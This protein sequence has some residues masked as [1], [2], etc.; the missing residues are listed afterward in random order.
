M[1]L[2]RAIEGRLPYQVRRW[3]IRRRYTKRNLTVLEERQHP[4]GP[5]LVIES[6]WLCDG[7]DEGP[8]I[9]VRALGEE[10]WRIDL[11]RRRPHLHFN[12]IDNR[13]TRSTRPSNLLLSSDEIDPAMK[14]LRKNFAFPFASNRRRAL[15]SVVIDPAHYEPA[16]N[17]AQLHLE[18]LVNERMVHG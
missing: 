3:I 11:L 7:G 13:A 17:A 12:V 9:S 1:H 5:G 18:G 15:R 10:V 16:I 6:Y 8:A 14:L 4:A 2:G